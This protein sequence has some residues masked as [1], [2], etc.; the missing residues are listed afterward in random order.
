MISQVS[1]RGCSRAYILCVLQRA[2]QYVRQRRMSGHAVSSPFSAAEIEKW[3]IQARTDCLD[4]YFQQLFGGTDFNLNDAS[5]YWTS[6][7]HFFTW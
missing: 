4:P 2:L 1:S 6:T 3:L 5:T 7:S